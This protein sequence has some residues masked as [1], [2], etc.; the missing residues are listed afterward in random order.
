MTAM[1]ADL[2]KIIMQNGR[3]CP[4]KKL[5]RDKNHDYKA[6]K[7]KGGGNTRKDAF[8]PFLTTLEDKPNHKGKQ[9]MTFSRV[10]KWLESALGRTEPHLE[11][12]K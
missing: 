6:K 5:S 10:P 8:L 4:R 1:D 3:K 11:T 9:N 12:S 7:L 2:I